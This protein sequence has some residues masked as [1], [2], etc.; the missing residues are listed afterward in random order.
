MTPHI[1]EQLSN[2]GWS[3]ET[4]KSRTAPTNRRLCASRTKVLLD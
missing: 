3:V 4:T 2:P 1:H